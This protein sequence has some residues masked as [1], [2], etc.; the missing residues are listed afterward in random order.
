MP[1]NPKQQE[2]VT[3]PGIQLI[4]AGLGPGK[5]RVNTEKILHLIG[6]EAAPGG[7]LPRDVIH[8]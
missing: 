2:A 7:S 4:L 3:T 5:T 6:G 1:L 8:E